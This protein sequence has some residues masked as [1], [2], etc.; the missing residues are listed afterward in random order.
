MAGSPAQHSLNSS[1]KPPSWL[2]DRGLQEA[3]EGV[4][5]VKDHAEERFKAAADVLKRRVG[6]LE[7]IRIGTKHLRGAIGGRDQN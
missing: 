5:I 4:Y 3:E 7:L 6:R 1:P 2:L